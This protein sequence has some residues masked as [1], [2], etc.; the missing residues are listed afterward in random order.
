MNLKSKDLKGLKAAF[1]SVNQNMDLNNL[2][3]G[4]ALSKV[5][6]QKSKI[7]MEST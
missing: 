3:I 6:V 2:S 5:D 1:D 7:I 4:R